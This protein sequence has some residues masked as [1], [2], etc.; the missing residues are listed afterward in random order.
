MAYRKDQTTVA[1]TAANTSATVVAA[2]VTAGVIQDVETAKAEFDSI[3]T[4]TFADLI[5]VVAEDNKVFAAAEAAA[6]AK[7]SSSKG[8]GDK[9]PVTVEMA[10][11]T[12]LTFGKFAGAEDE[13]GKKTP[14]VS[15]GELETMTKAQTA[16]Y[17]YETGNGL[18]YMKYLSTNENNEFIAKRALLILEDRKASSDS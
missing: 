1:Q 14:G 8:G 15:L 6:P 5:Q 13:N 2:L 17:G 12:Q 10:R 9:G 7:R 11:A 16:E 3:R 18:A 4:S